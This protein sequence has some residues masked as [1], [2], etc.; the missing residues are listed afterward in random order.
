MLVKW[1]VR[2]TK[3]VNP[4]AVRDLRNC[5]ET[6]VLLIILELLFPGG[7]MGSKPAESRISDRNFSV[8]IIVVVVVNF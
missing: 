3:L 1:V 4:G 5:V 2:R 6:R 8:V 7:K